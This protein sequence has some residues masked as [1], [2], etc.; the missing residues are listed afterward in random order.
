MKQNRSRTELKYLEMRR[1]EKNESKVSGPDENFLSS[2]ANQYKRVGNAKSKSSLCPSEKEIF[3]HVRAGRPFELSGQSCFVD[4]LAIDHSEC[5]R[6]T[7]LSDIN[8]IYSHVS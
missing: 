8:A 6:N 4:S 7:G 2:G 5:C 1:R 3:F